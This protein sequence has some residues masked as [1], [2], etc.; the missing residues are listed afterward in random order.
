MF[1]GH[2]EMLAMAPVS[3]DFDGFHHEGC[4]AGFDGRE[5][6]N[7]RG[8]KALADKSPFWV[9]LRAEVG[10]D[11]SRLTSESSKLMTISEYIE[12]LLDWRHV[13]G[14]LGSSNHGNSFSNADTA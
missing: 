10:S 12:R 1:I 2:G 7:A 13:S 8:T 9:D 14:C 6:R 3:M 5:T 4:D 11:G